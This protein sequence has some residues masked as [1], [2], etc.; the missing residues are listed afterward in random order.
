MME[1]ADEDFESSPLPDRI[2]LD[3]LEELIEEER[4]DIHT[5]QGSL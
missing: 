5:P 3:D 1:V 2:I 4:V